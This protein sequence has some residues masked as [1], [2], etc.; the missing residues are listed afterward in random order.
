MLGVTL[1]DGVLLLKPLVT[2]D[3]QEW[4]EGE[5]EEQ[6]R[7]FEAPRPA[8]LSDV[9]NFIA[10]CQASWR[11]SGDHRHWGI[12]R[13]GSESL[14]GGVDVRVL[15]SEVVN[16]SYLVFPQFR[17]QGVARGA[18]RLVLNYAALSM[19][20]KTGVIKM[21]PENVNSKYLASSLGA[22]RAGKEPSDAGKTFEVFNVSLPLL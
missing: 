15:S 7:W 3:A 8:R 21:L 18:S 16:L 17:R 19:G 1:T 13:V 5:D 22:V 14:L 12:R 10:S 6:L 11:I 2:T 4:L 20:A 9:Q